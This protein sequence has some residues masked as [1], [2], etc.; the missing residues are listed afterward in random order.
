MGSD[1]APQQLFNGIIEATSLLPSNTQCLVLAT[2]DIISQLSPLVSSRSIIFHAAKAEIKMEDDPL[3]AV[4]NRDA[5]LMVGIDLLKQ[6]QI[7]ALVSAGNTGALFAASTLDLPHLPGIK[8]PALLVQLPTRKRP[9]VVLD[10]GGNVS[11]SAQ[12]LVQFAQLGV[13]YQRC[14][15]GL[16]S[17]AVGLLNIGVESGKGTSSLRKAYQALIAQTQIQ[18]ASFHFVGNIEA[19][20][21]FAGDVDVLVTDGF[22]GNVLLKSA[23]GIASFILEEFAG[24]ISGSSRNLSALKRRFSYTEYPGALVCG[25]EGVVIKCHGNATA[26]T[27]LSSILWAATLVEKQFIAAMRALLA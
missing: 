6:G 21:I 13:A 3:Q 5:S 1:T 9:L 19:R 24:E 22:T 12:H 8:R 11:C 18:D 14:T 23:E 7:D 26:Q 25:V 10:V 15:Q 16:G 27:F 20:E 2:P 17:P 4:E